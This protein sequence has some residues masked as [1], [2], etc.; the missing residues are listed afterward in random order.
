MSTIDVGCWVRNRDA[1]A[2]PTRLYVSPEEKSHRRFRQAPCGCTRLR[3][4]PRAPLK[5]RG[6]TK[7]KAHHS[8][9]YEGEEK[10]DHMNHCVAREG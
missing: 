5:R 6:S 1:V 8:K 9:G 2:M 10:K 7:C 4:L 3:R